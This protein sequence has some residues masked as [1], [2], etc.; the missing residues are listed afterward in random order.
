MAAACL[1]HCCFELSCRHSFRIPPDLELY[2]PKYP[3]QK[4]PCASLSFRILCV[5]FNRCLH[6]SLQQASCRVVLKHL[7]PCHHLKSTLRFAYY[8]ATVCL[9]QPAARTPAY[10][11]GGCEAYSLFCLDISELIFACYCANNKAS[12]PQIARG[13]VVKHI[14]GAS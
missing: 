2:M 13:A 5:G 10:W 8:C 14:F 4:A 3:Y 7:I 11:R 12:H 1:V 9:V 6:R